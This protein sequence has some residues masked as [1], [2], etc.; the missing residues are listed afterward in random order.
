M[1]L[2]RHA[3]RLLDMISAG[4]SENPV[5]PTAESL[6][7][8]MSRLAEVADARQ[9]HVGGVE[10]RTAPGPAGP[11]GL[12]V[13]TPAGA[14]PGA[15]PCIVYFHGGTGVFCGISTHDGLC[16][17]LA[18]AS[19]CRVFSVEYRL[20][21]EH[22]FPAALDDAIAATTW[23]AE[24]AAEF[25]I[26]A[27]RLV[28]AGDSAG[29]TMAAVVCQLAAETGTLQ[30]ALQLLLCP[31]TDLADES[32]SRRTFAQGYFIERGTLAWAKKAYCGDADYF[33]PRVS[34]LRAPSLAGLPP[35]HIHTAEFDPMRDEGEA[36][37]RKLAEAGVP[38]RYTCHPGMIHHFYCMAGAIPHARNVLASIGAAVREA[39]TEAATEAIS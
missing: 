5:E 23:I 18:N 32:E 30:F 21:P 29:G 31:V 35:A 4:R 10:E 17:L 28:V 36:F 27:T 9:V 3:K 20:A 34:P 15:I 22:P 39:L 26:D 19:G 6:R 38:V 11:I 1:P 13:Y 24:N 2:D 37:A 16:R 7:R 33:D 14:D 25:G 8:S 12:R